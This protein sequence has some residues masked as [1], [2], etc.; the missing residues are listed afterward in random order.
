MAAELAGMSA[1]LILDDSEV[2]NLHTRA[3]MLGRPD[4]FAALRRWEAVDDRVWSSREDEYA[5]YRTAVEQEELLGAAVDAVLRPFD[6]S[7][8]EPPDATESAL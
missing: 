2:S 3:E 1:S 5:S 8:V 4:L 6:E 7:W